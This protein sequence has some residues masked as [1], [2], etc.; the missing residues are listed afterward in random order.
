MDP[1]PDQGGPFLFLYFF[2]SWLLASPLY[3]TLVQAYNDKNRYFLYP[4]SENIL[5][6]DSLNLD[7]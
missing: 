3:S 4:D 2:Y 6:P 5:N 1:D 7:P